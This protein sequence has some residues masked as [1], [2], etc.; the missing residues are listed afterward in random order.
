MNN[1]SVFLSL[2]VVPQFSRATRKDAL[3]CLLR[4]PPL[5]CSRVSTVL[6]RHSQRR[7]CVLTA[8]AA[9]SLL[10]RFHSSLAP[11][12]KTHLRAYCGCRRFFAPAFPQ[13]TRATRKDALTCL[14]RLSP[15]LCSYTGA[16]SA[17]AGPGCSLCKHKASRP[18]WAGELLLLYYILFLLI[19]KP[20]AFLW[21][22]MVIYAVVRNELKYLVLL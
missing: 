18:A 1:L 15:L 19:R 17:H 3:A 21:V 9:A 22:S 11:L 12:A 8:A 2:P 20:L 5:L 14:L 10:P 16:H 13:F 6:P 4:L 7:T